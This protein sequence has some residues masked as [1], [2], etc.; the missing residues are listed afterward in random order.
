MQPVNS[1]IRTKLHQPFTRPGLVPRPRL[2]T[3]VTQGLQGPLTLIIAPAGFG[4][5][6]LVAA[7]LAD[8]HMP[9]AWLSLDRDDNQAGRFLNYLIAAFQGVDKKIGSEAVQLLAGIDQAHPEVVLTSL[10]NDLDTLSGELALVLDDYQLI[11]TSEVHAA[12]AFLL[13]H[14]PKSFHLL[15]STR[16]DPPLPLARLRARGQLVELRAADLRFTEPEAAQFLNELMGLRLDA[17]SVAV[18][19]ERTEGWVAGLQMASI[20]LQSYLSLRDQKDVFAYIEGFSG[21]NRYILDYMLEEVLASQPP[22]IQHFLLYTSILKRLTASLCD[23]VLENKAGGEDP[24]LRS[25]ARILRHSDSILDYLEKANLFLAPLD[26]ERIWYRYHHLFADLLRARLEQTYPGLAPQLHARAAAWLEQAGIMVE[27]VDQAL[28]AGAL[29]LAARL[30]EE[31]T[32]R[33]LA[34]GELNALMGWT[35][36]LPAELRMARPWLCIHQAYALMLAGRTVEVEPLLAQAE[37]WLGQR[38]SSQ[39]GQ[40]DTTETL[41]MGLNEAR[42]LKGA[43]AAVRAFCAEHIGQSVEALTQVQLARESLPADDL[44]A[45]SVVA[46]AFGE[47]MFTQ[48]HLPEARLAFEEQ[49]RLGRA[50]GN[51]WSMVA[52]HTYMAQVLQAQGQLHQARA[53][54]EETLAKASQQGV[55]SRGYIA[56]VENGLASVLYELNE[57][58]TA[59]QSLTEAILLI[60]HWPNTNHLIY[61]YVLQTRVL[62]AQGDYQGARIAI[63]KADHFIRTTY[64]ARRLRRT[65][66][67]ELVRVWLAF[68]AAGASLVSGDSLAEQASALVAAWRSEMANIMATENP[69]M[70]ENAETTALTLA[71]TSLATGQTEEALLLLAHLT[72]SAKAAGHTGVAISSLV[73]TA[74]ARQAGSITQG[75]PIEAFSELSEALRLAEPGGYVRV[76]LNEGRPMQF[77][78]AQWLAHASAGPLRDCVIHLLAQFDTELPGK[79][80]VQEKATF[81]NDQV[82]SRAQPAQDALIEPL[83]QRELEVLHLMAQG[84]A[85][86]QIARQLIVATGTVKAHAASI[87]RKLDVANRTEAVASAR[88]LGLLP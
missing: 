35:E 59:N 48:G 33:L 50:M 6:T 16:S 73:L 2:Q 88:R 52:G 72:E 37:V 30:V 19:E 39:P 44:F 25:E 38:K 57:L 86:Q 45:Q 53:I 17:R 62:L 54:L 11:S 81:I 87:Y 18:L 41:T 36:M 14:C 31:N 60:R 55:R 69:L 12:V 13:D 40:E 23:A 66:E 42:S 28:E 84:C 8:Y 61:T 79:T 29:D 10:I 58:E 68:Q 43:V 75:K 49:H 76:F 34:Q 65:V 5:T 77:L 27:A 85:N 46:W 22:E 56:R 4:K 1:L 83:S 70:D 82:A 78:L 9:V 20:A 3:R 32:T 80:A 67:A 51:P 47:T 24:S 15:I 21:T 64:R 74:V 26:D 7:S 71:R 63:G